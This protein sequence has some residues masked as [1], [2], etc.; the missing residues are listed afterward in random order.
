MLSMGRRTNLPTYSPTYEP[1]YLPTYLPI[2][3]APRH[4]RPMELQAF[5]T[6]QAPIN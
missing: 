2:V 6:E 4:R 3:D 5:A 1:T